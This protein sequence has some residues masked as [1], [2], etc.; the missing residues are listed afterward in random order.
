MAAVLVGVYWWLASA[1]VVGHNSSYQQ[2]ASLDLPDLFVPSDNLGQIA[3]IAVVA[4]TGRMSY[5]LARLT[6]DR[7]PAGTRR[8]SRRF[9]VLRLLRFV[10]WTTTLAAATWVWWFQTANAPIRRWWHPWYDLAPALQF[11]GVGLLVLLAL[12]VADALDAVRRWRRPS[13]G[14]RHGVT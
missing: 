1:W 12:L 14:P 2:P 8:P 10:A 13:A 6:L 5:L 3:M 11:V 4:Y 9:L 7:P